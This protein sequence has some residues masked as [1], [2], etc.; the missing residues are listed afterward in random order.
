MDTKL[1]KEIKEFLVAC[2]N[3]HTTC[4][5]NISQGSPMNPF[6]V[7]VKVRKDKYSNTETYVFYIDNISGDVVGVPCL[8]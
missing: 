2:K 8:W 6:E 5:H 4:E 1:D 3:K 7:T